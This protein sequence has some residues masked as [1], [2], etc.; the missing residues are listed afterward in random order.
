MISLNE[1]L[2][3][4]SL[5]GMDQE[6]IKNLEEL[7]LRMNKIR[8][9]LNKP[10]AVTSG[11]RSPEDQLRIY[12]ARGISD[13][14]IPMG[15]YHLKGAAVDISDLDGSLFNWCVTNTALLE[16]VGLWL[17]TKDTQKRVHFQIFPP[18]SGNRF[19]NP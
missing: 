19:F 15:S 5:F 11:Y 2:S 17:E 18:K 14:K 16:A 7:Q 3:G 1:L 13:D 10:M 9:A 8:I 12:R 6:H 4:H